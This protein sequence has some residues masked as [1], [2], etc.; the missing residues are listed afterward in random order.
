MESNA[1]RWIGKSAEVVLA[2]SFHE[3]RN[4]ILLITGYLSVLKSTELPEE[5][6]QH[7]IAEA[8]D[9]ALSAKDIVEAVFQYMNEKGKEG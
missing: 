5:Q 2:E 3:L 1:N 8:L 4:P 7:L 9:R 6:R